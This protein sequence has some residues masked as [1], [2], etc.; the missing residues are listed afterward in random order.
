[1]GELADDATVDARVNGLIA[2][3]AEYIDLGA[4]STRPGATPLT[5]DQEWARLAPALERFLARYQGAVL[6]PRVSID[7]YHLGTARRALALGV[8]V[9]N[10]VSGLT[11]PAMA[12]LAASSNADWVAMHNL[13]V[14]ADKNK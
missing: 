2:G 11:S 13:G 4:E 7:T 9:I 14:P 8:D 6:R 10:D 3:G 5:A 12:E 1:G